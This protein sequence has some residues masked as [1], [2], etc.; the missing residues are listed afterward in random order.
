MKNKASDTQNAYNGSLVSLRS[1][2]R[3]N[4]EELSDFADALLCVSFAEEQ[5]NA[6]N[7]RECNDRIN[8]T[9]EER[10]LAAEDPG[11]K[12]KLEKTDASPVERTDDRQNERK[13]VEHNEYPSFRIGNDRSTAVIV[14]A[15]KNFYSEKRKSFRN[16]KN[17]DE[18]QKNGIANS[19]ESC[20]NIQKQYLF[21]GKKNYEIEK[22]KKRRSAHGSMR[23]Y[24]SAV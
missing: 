5:R 1:G 12:V 2:V 3:I 21:K 10:L 19:M 8:D 16:G 14:S 15:F 17:F 7:A 23:R 9:A 11:D 20:Y 4:S 24:H 13:S 18:K 22:K 6:P